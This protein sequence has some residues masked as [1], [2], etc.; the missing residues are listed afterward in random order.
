MTAVIGRAPNA[1]MSMAAF[2]ATVTSSTQ[3]ARELHGSSANQRSM[4]WER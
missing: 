4:P 3:N 2:R 1:A